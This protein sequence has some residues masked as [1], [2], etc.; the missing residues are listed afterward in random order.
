MDGTTESYTKTIIR[1]L[2][3][4]FEDEDENQQAGPY[5]MDELTLKYASARKR[6]KPARAILSSTAI[7]SI[8]SSLVLV[9]MIRRSH[10]GLSSTNT[11]LLIGLCI[12]DLMSSSSYSVLAIWVP[13]E[14]NYYT[15]S[16][17]GNATTC[18][19]QGCFCIFGTFSA[20]LYNCSL[21]SY[22]HNIDHSSEEYNFDDTT[23]CMV[24]SRSTYQ[25]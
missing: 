23:L 8:F 19:I 24:S 1:T 22:I 18:T 6:G 2:S 20:T 10:V 15:W 5:S 9:W 14:L 16:A 7:I 25:L 17:I 21:V 12:A 11:R 4:I 3:E 13:S